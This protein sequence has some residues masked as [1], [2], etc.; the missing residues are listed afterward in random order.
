MHYTPASLRLALRLATTMLMATALAVAGTALESGLM[1][2]IRAAETSP[3]SSVALTAPSSS[4]AGQSISLAAR[5][6]C[7]G[8][9]E[10]AF[11]SRSNPSIAW[12]LVRGWGGANFVAAGSF[13]GPV[14]FLVWATD[15][16][17]T[18]PQIQRQTGVDFGSASQPACTS[19]SISSSTRSPVPGQSVSF[20]A[21]ATC[22][23]SA[24][25][26]YAYFSRSSLSAPWTLRAAWIGPTWTWTAPGATGSYQVLA[27]A[28]DGPTTVPQ[29]Q[30][31]TEVYDGVASTCTALL[32]HATPLGGASSQSIDVTATSTCAQG[33][34]P[35]YSY[36]VG[37]TANG[38]WTLTAAWIGSSWTWEPPPTASGTEY[39]LVWASDGPYTVPQVQA[40]VGTVIGHLS[41]CTVVS[42]TA[43]PAGSAT[44][45]GDV[46]IAASATCPAGST[47]EFSYFTGPSTSG[48]WTLE[49]AWTGP[50]WTWQTT[51][52]AVGTYYVLV[53]A[54]GGPYTVPQVQTAMPYRLSSDAQTS[55]P[56]P[57][58]TSGTA[59]ANTNPLSDPLAN[60][61]ST[62]MSTC[63][64][65]G[66]ASP[67]CGQAEVANIDSALASEGLGPL[68]WPTALYSLPLGQQEFIV[69][70]EERLERGLL[71]ITGMAATADANA[72]AAAQAAQD[73][74]GQL[75]P[76]AIASFG[77]WAEDFGPL[78]SDFNW[79]YNDGP[80]SFNI[81]CPTSGSPGCWVHRNDILANTSVA[82]L[83][84]P[85]GYAWVAGAACVTDTSTTFL[86]NCD[87]EYV[88]LPASTL[89][90]DFTWSEAL[91][92]GAG[93]P[94]P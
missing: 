85:T 78:G 75:L 9:P 23:P 86:S 20:T 26:K 18:I 53:W 90:Y 68:V 59:P 28:T 14:Q 6:V 24:L 15:G 94:T 54:S 56:N 61:S 65:A 60:L 13:A 87:L 40:S 77:N 74:Q 80:G 79:M 32:V 67:S 4:P 39:F 47:A 33:S 5:A 71:P 42:A 64:Q 63:W 37:P 34:S 52:D 7:G 44:V 46:T 30:T 8:T 82:P 12:T 93:T 69:T 76:G 11:F 57:S 10:F 92:L 70:N 22:P 51:G 88:L 45:G 62:F 84:A 89:S 17:L 16:P 73:P 21:D 1:P 25:V 91:A 36:F 2:T 3:C 31:A 81:D 83:A 29:V 48:P 43:S 50:T 49:D 58:P 41:G 27:W 38:P 55:S 66:Y 35:E 19:I 72:L